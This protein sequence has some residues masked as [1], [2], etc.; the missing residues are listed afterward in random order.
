MYYIIIIDS[1][2]LWYG[3]TVVAVNVQCMVARYR[4]DNDCRLST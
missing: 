3:S 1:S 4:P 2:Q